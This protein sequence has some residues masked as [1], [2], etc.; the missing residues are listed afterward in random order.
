MVMY[1]RSLACYANNLTSH[2][3]DKTMDIEITIKS[4]NWTETVKAVGMRM[5]DYARSESLHMECIADAIGKVIG[6]YGMYR[7]DDCD[8]YTTQCNVRGR[9]QRISGM[10]LY[11]TAQFCNC[12][13]AR[14]METEKAAG[15]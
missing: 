4:G 11:G 12:C 1:Q 7:C 14:R 15:L 3:R 8:A 6:Q 13:A 2:E 5:P 10:P 9:T